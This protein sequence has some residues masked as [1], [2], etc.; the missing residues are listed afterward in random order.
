MATVLLLRA[1]ESCEALTFLLEEEGHVVAHH[2][3]LEVEWP[4]DARALVA[5]AESVGRTRWI[6]PDSVQAVRAFAEAVRVAGTRALAR[7]VRWVALEDP[8][9]KAVQRAGWGSQ[10]VQTGTSSQG[11][12]DP[13]WQGSLQGLIESDD[14][15]LVLHEVGR[16]PSWLE[17]LQAGRGRTVSV[18]AW[19]AGQAAPVEP[20]ELIVVDSALGAEAVLRAEW[21]S[22]ARCVCAPEGAGPLVEA[23]R[24][25]VI[26]QAGHAEGLYEAVLEAL[27]QTAEVSSK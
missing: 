11:C 10:V 23:G 8:I 3:V 9:A 16:P 27:T 22:R 20:A 1:R 12:C 14:E 5:A 7:T 15:L 19:Q 13:G 6:V 17:E 25:A 21:A 26:A 24:V 2:P 4:A 18:S